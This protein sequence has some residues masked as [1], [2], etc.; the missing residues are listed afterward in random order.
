MYTL[1]NNISTSCCPT[2]LS[3]SAKANRYKCVQHNLH[4]QPINATNRDQL[5]PGEADRTSSRQQ[6][7]TT[8]I[9]PLAIRK[10]LHLM[11]YFLI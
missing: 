7:S 3:Q 5:S 1:F 10:L 8:H 11:F 9:L 2:Y 6:M 4:N